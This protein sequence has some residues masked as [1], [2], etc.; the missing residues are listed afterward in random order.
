MSP[1]TFESSADPSRFAPLTRDA[2]AQTTVLILKGMVR[3]A[4]G[5]IAGL[6]DVA[7]RAMPLPFEAVLSINRAAESVRFSMRVLS[8]A[9]QC[10]TYDVIDELWEGL[11]VDDG[12]RVVIERTNARIGL[13]LELDLAEGTG[14]WTWR[15]RRR[16]PELGPA[17]SSWAAG[18]VSD[19]R[20][21]EASTG[22]F[23]SA[24]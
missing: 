4:R 21:I 15:K 19:V 18:T 24:C 9:H 16:L 12:D 2:K 11:T 5:V 20:T 14:L 23:A 13:T 10:A 3:S 8:G 6:G 1:A 7:D 17:Q 22:A